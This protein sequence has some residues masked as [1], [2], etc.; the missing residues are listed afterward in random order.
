MKSK[1]RERERERR[2]ERGCAVGVCIACGL[3][4]ELFQETIPRVEWEDRE[5]LKSKTKFQKRKGRPCEAATLRACVPARAC[6][7]GEKGVERTRRHKS[8]R[9]LNFDAL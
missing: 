1:G 8:M 6:L 9:R 7:S 3:R 2:R 5:Q 4:C